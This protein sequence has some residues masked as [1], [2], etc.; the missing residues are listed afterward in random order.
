MFERVMKLADDHEDKLVEELN[1]LSK[2][3]VSRLNLQT[4]T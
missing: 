2:N 3:S 4:N 1:N